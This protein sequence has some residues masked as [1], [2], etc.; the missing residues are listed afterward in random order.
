MQDLFNS[1]SRR[2][3][4]AI[5]KYLEHRQSHAY[6]QLAQQQ[7]QSAFFAGFGNAPGIGAVIEEFQQ[8]FT[9]GPAAWLR[10]TGGQILATAI[11]AGNTPT[12]TLRPGLVMGIQ[13]ATGNWTNYSP[14]ATDGSQIALGVLPVGLPMVDP[15][16]GLTQTKN[17]GILMAG[18]LQ[19]TKC[20][21]LDLFARV[22]LRPQFL[23]DDFITGVPQGAFRFQYSN[24]VSKTA[25]YSVLATDNYTLFDNTGATG[26]ITFTLPAIANGYMFGFRVVANQNVLITSNEGG[27]I[28]AL[29]NAAANTLAFQTGS[30]LIGGN[31]MLYTNP[32]GT[33]WIAENSS[34]G[35]NTITVS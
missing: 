14:T 16:S 6:Q 24:F 30:Q 26:A 3:R 2:T 29:N 15:L 34:A 9:W 33:K 21:G 17:W 28:I 19:A 4:R 32:A 7:Q 12:T 25:S 22:N 20:L 18:G 8:A 23:F 1:L 11:D 31:I 35:T 13:T 10:Y 5:R 27:N